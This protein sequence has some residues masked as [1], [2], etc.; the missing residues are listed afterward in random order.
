MDKFAHAV[1]YENELKLAV[2]RFVTLN[3]ATEL[4]NKTPAEDASTAVCALFDS[5]TSDALDELLN[6]LLGLGA[7]QKPE[8]RDA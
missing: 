4:S 3:V 8:A 6:A 2:K 5:V 1:K 7:I